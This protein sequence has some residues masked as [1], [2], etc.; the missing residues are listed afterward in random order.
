[1]DLLNEVTNGG[2][3]SGRNGPPHDLGSVAEVL[4]VPDQGPDMDGSQ[5]YPTWLRKDFAKLK[6]YCLNDVILTAELFDRL[7]S[8]ELGGRAFASIRKLSSPK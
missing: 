2:S 8:Q 6:E 7:Y 1:V 3:T 5:V 4:G